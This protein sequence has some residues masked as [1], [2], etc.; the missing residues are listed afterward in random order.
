[1]RNFMQDLRDSGVETGGPAPFGPK[2]KANFAN[3][4]N[5][6]ITKMMK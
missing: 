3:S 2:D 1:M 5:K 4:L 6:I